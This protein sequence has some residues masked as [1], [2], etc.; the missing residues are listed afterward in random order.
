MFQ[1][2]NATA[3]CEPA[4][5]RSCYGVEHRLPCRQHRVLWVNCHKCGALLAASARSQGVAF[6]TA[7]PPNKA[8][9]LP[10]GTWDL[11]PGTWDLPETPQQGHA[12]P[13]RTWDLGPGTS[14]RPPNKATQ[15]PANPGAAA[16][17][18]TPWCHSRRLATTG[19]LVL[20]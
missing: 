14:P 19:M 10:E 9:H 1:C 6:H 18:L 13:S 7:W 20:P 8:M 5:P 16:F 12:P 2:T 15:L 4:P 17:P 11:G 3:T